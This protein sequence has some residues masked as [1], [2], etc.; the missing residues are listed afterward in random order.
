MIQLASAQAAKAARNGAPAISASEAA[1]NRAAAAPCER[2][3]TKV[4]PATS[5]I[6]AI[7]AATASYRVRYA[8]AS[9]RPS[10]ANWI[11]SAVRHQAS[12]FW[13]ARTRKNRKGASLIPFAAY[14]TIIGCSANA[15]ASNPV[16][17][18]PSP[19]STSVLL[20]TRT[21]PAMNSAETML[22]ANPAETKGGQIAFRGNSGSIAR[23]GRGFQTKP[24]AARCGSRLNSTYEA[25]PTLLHA[26]PTMYPSVRTRSQA[27]ARYRASGSQKATREPV[28][29]R[30]RTRTDGTASLTPREATSD[31]D[32][33]GPRAWKHGVQT[34][35]RLLPE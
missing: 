1:A 4:R 11:V 31:R 21:A 8:P 33:A 34:V 7:D 22:A 18:A 19:A 2:C 15:S 25:L 17:R 10:D 27:T 13:I 23:D 16:I 5:P 14:N 32:I 29:G 12:S 20:T 3:W 9:A 6:A 24:M 30:H 26:S 35:G 28:P